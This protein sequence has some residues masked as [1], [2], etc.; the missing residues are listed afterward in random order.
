MGKRL[1]RYKG[2]LWFFDG[3]DYKGDYLL[4]SVSDD[5]S[6]TL[7]KPIFCHELTDEEYEKQMD[8]IKYFKYER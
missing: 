7:A 2:S 1:F 8:G 3:I 4:T 5:S 6:G